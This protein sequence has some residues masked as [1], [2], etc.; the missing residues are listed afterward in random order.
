MIFGIRNVGELHG[1]LDARTRANMQ[2][3]IAAKEFRWLVATDVA[4]RG[5]DIDG[6][7]HIISVDLPNDLDY[8]V[9]PKRKNWKKTITTGKSYVFI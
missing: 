1:D 5:I 2:K 8:Y 6:V 3:R 7:S 9:S 4:A